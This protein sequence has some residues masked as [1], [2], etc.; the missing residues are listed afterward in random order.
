MKTSLGICLALILVAAPAAAAQNDNSASGATA[1]T[2]TPAE[3]P[4][5][6]KKHKTAKKAATTEKP[7]RSGAAIYKENGKTCSGLDQYKVCW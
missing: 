5:K 7:V 3:H 2:Q 1:A 6:H 4:V